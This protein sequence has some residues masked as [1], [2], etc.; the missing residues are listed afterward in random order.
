MINGTSVH[1][2]IVFT[3]FYFFVDEKIKLK[4]LAWTFKIT[5]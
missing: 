4:D 2:L 5:Y 1:A 3:I